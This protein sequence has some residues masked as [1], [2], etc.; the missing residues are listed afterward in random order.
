MKKLIAFA[1]VLVMLFSFTSCNLF[2]WESNGSDGAPTVNNGESDTPN[3]SDNDAPNNGDNDTPNNGENDTPND[4]DNDTPSAE[5]T[6]TAFTPDEEQLYIDIFGEVI[7][8]I[9]NN[10]YSVEEYSITAEYTTTK[11]I[12]FFIYG[13]TEAEF[14]AYRELFAVNGEPFTY[15]GDLDVLWYMYGSADGSYVITMAYYEYE[16]EYILHVSA[17]CE[18]KGG[19]AG[20][21]NGIPYDELFTN[22]GAGLPE[23]DDGI[24][25]LDFTKG[26]YVKDTSEQNTYLNGCPP[27]GSPGVLVIPVQFS[28][29]TAESRGITIDT[30]AQVLVEGG[31]NDY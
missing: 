19:S 10:E 22:E 13:K 25:D 27:T 4:D 16:G 26:E 29:I 11:G 21:A 23:D 1:L 7:P 14:D 24:Y 31:K 2:W 12:D 18:V 15:V 6:H 3:N 28:D 30:I 9:P 20:I 5:Y 17:Y 8:F